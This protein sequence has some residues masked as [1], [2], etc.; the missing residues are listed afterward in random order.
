MKVT[1][2]E[3]LQKIKD[4]EIKEGFKIQ[5]TNEWNGIY[6][7]DGFDFRT[8]DNNVDIMNRYNINEF[9]ITEFEILEENKEIEEIKEIEYY[10]INGEEE[11]HNEYRLTES[12]NYICQHYDEFEMVALRKIN[13]IARRVNE[14]ERKVNKLIKEM[15]EK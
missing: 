5:C 3:L 11:Q 7:Y 15:E 1:G 9:I 2:I 4:N 14:T 12:D 6:R 13:E 8:I 10:E